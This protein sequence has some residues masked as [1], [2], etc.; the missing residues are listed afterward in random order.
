M[1]IA[2]G[3]TNAAKNIGFKKIA[4]DIWPDVEY[5]SIETDSN[6]SAQPLTL[7]ETILGAINRANY[8]LQKVP[9]AIYGVG[10][11]GGV[12]RNTYGMF[13]G[14][15]VVI[16]DRKGVT[17]I[18]SSAFVQVPED[19]AYRLDNGEEMGIITQ[20]LSK[21][22]KNNIRHSIGTAGILT[23]QLYIRSQE[24]E[25]ATKCALAKLLNPQFYSGE[26]FKKK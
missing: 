21:D 22:D 20:E 16:V 1:L 13:L 9:N 14:G 6:I 17:G 10:M 8:A 4:S 26:Y 24:F 5:T 15:W 18:G 11:E 19:F 2:I 7:D 12:F 3:T 25:D 23:G